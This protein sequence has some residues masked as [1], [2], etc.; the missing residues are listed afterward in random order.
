M[1]TRQDGVENRDK[2]YNSLQT[3]KLKVMPCPAPFK[4]GISYEC[5]TPIVVDESTTVDSDVGY[6]GA[7]FNSVCCKYSQSLEKCLSNMGKGLYN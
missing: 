7:E 2:V 6:D 5:R 1:P 3:T 4:R